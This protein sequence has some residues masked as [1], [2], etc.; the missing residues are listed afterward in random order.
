MKTILAFDTSGRTLT[1]ALE[2]RGMLLCHTAEYGL[3]HSEHLIPAV[4][5]ILEQAECTLSEV[6]LIAVSCGPGSFTGLRISMSTA[7]GLAFGLDIPVVSVPTLDVYQQQFSWF[8]G[9]VMPVID[10][11]KNRYYTAAYRGGKRES[12][13]LDLKAQDIIETASPSLPVLFAGPDA[14]ALRDELSRNGISYPQGIYFQVH[15]TSPPARSLI[16]AAGRCYALH[17]PDHITAGP[18]Y[19]RKSEAESLHADKEINQK[20]ENAHET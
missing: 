18:L 19:I 17:G 1:A 7:K 5:R 4:R 12:D 16:E 9:T 11:R 10:A 15:D 6:D 20:E 13:F 3:R 14:Q 2:H 8:D